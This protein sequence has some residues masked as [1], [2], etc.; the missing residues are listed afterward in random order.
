MFYYFNLQTSI[1]KDEILKS[2]P[3]DSTKVVFSASEEEE[4]FLHMA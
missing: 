2:F 1:Y 3:A 4:A